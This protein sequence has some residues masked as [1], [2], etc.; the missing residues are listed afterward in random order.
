[1]NDQFRRL[2]FL[3]TAA[4]LFGKDTEDGQQKK[5]AGYNV[6]IGLMSN[7]KK[8]ISQHEG[9]SSQQHQDGGKNT[10]DPGDDG[11]KLHN[12]QIFKG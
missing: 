4:T 5:V 1:V 12:K 8:V 11:V 6:K 7:A 10:A 9:D 2:I 3:L